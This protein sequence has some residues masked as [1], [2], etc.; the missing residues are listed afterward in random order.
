MRK[1]LLLAATAAATA[2]LVMVPAAALG[3]AA[4]HHV[5]TTGK[6]GGPNVKVG[7]V[8]R[9]GLKAGTVLTFSSTIANL[10]CTKSTVT[11]KVTANPAR[12]GTAT[13]SVTAETVSGCKAVNPPVPVTSVTVTVTKLPYRSTVSDARGFPVTVFGSSAT[14]K[15][16]ATGVG[17]IICKYSARTIKGKASN[18]GSLISFS[19]QV[20]NKAA[21]SNA[22]CPAKGALTV[23][24]G[25]VVDLSVTGHPHV[26]VN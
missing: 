19:K 18:T 11:S 25:P 1:S 3:A 24:Y 16:V 4:P 12:P 7:A 21:G 2:M 20:F 10:K 14:I 23:T 6:V 5:L 15:I 9:A 17:T 8:L 22:F 26:F 13:E